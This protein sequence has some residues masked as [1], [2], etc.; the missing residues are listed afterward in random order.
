VPVEFALSRVE[1]GSLVVHPLDSAR[2]FGVDAV[3]TDRFGG[4]SEPPYD[5]LNLGDHVG[6]EPA[7]V[8]E[9]RRRVAKAMG[10]APERLITMRQV[11]GHAALEVRGPGDPVTADALV[12]EVDGLALGVLV[13][14]CVPLLVVDASSPR[15]A[16]VHA[17]W[18]GLA[19]G[20]IASAIHAFDNPS[21]LHVV[22]GPSISPARYQVGPEVAEHFAHVPGAVTPDAGDRSRL[23]LRRVA[24][25]QLVALGVVEDHVEVVTQSTDG[26]AEFFSDRAARPCGRFGLFARRVLA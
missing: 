26:G 8:A 5:E 4:V 16:V 18:R 14:D 20:V 7:R 15:F 13:A 9:N 24:T 12:C 22:I 23:D 3:I 6:D 17:G 2:E 19:T 10:V 1:R 25:H 21:S 11:H